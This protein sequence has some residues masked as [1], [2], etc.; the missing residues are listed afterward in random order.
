MNINKYTYVFLTFSGLSWATRFSDDES[1][2]LSDNEDSLQS[3]FRDSPVSGGTDNLLRNLRPVTSINT[4]IELLQVASFYDTRCLDGTLLEPNLGGYLAADNFDEAIRILSQYPVGEFW[5][6]A[7]VAINFGFFYTHTSEKL[8][9]QWRGVCD[10]CGV[11]CCLAVF[12]CERLCVCFLR[13]CDDLCW[14]VWSGVLADRVLL[15]VMFLRH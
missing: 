9:K 3:I 13:V 8:R 15:R 4:S 7:R 6:S 10:V 2:G 14:C 11:R 12:D 5:S 1:D